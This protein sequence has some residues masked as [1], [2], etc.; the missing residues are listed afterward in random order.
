MPTAEQSPT[1][2][3]T[4]LEASVAKLKATYASGRTRDL[5][6]REVQ[7]RGLLR[8][9]HTEEAAIL[10]A[11]RQ[12]LGR[13]AIGAWMTDI[14]TVQAEVEYA[15]KHLRRWARPQ[16][17]KLPVTTWPS[18][19]YLVPEP[20]GAV[21]VIG[22]WNYPFN[23]TLCPVV[24]ALAAG[25]AVA[26]KPSEN[27]PASAS[28]MARLLPA[29]L[30]S[31]AIAV[32]EGDGSV[33]SELLKI[34]FDHCL[35]TG[36]GAIAR[37]VLAAAAESLTPVTLELGGKSPVIVTADADV[38]VAARRI[39]WA[40]VTNAGQTCI[41]CDYALVDRRV[42]ARF[43]EELSKA[44][45][46]FT[47]DGMQ[48]VVH[49]RHFDRLRALGAGHGG[50]V[51]YGG[52]SDES[53]LT[54]EPLVVLDPDLD[55]PL[56][57]D[58]IF[59][60]ILPVITVD[61]LDDAIRFIADRPRPLA[62]YLFSERAKDLRKV[63]RRTSS[64][65]VIHNHLMLHA[66]APQLPFGGVGAS[67]SGNYHGRFGFGTFSHMKPVMRAFTKPDL[68]VLY[69]PYTPEKVKLIRRVL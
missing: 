54:I 41:T 64:G 51:V 48:R 19:G 60:P 33:T 26:V 27:A 18:R 62:L 7:L 53:T 20:L 37:K 52:S 67:G 55:S 42:R 50:S 46:E 3:R 63:V 32:F 16:R 8:M 24:S 15:L 66:V 5:R 10:D 39:A 28:L 35:F 61:G 4:E 31:G 43:L 58:E 30:D 45:A 12:D 65:A 38:A 36:S 44:L 47:S 57:T 17:A 11:L 14:A 13:D 59:G 23:L 49:R 2:T 6:W 21:L 9:L 34:G 69:P 56:M 25:N 40:K 68:D 1:L 22:A 29:Y